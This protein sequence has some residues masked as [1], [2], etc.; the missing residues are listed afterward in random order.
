MNIDS[1]VLDVLSNAVINDNALTLTGTLDRKLYEA[2]NKVL[3]AAGGKWNRKAK[4]HLFD[5]EAAEIMDAIILTGKVTDKKS[6]LGYF[7]TPKAIVARLLELAHIE[8]GMSVAEP[9]AGQGAIAVEVYK[10]SGNVT[11]FELDKSNAIV[12]SQKLAETVLHDFKRGYP[13]GFEVHHGDFLA[14]EPNPIFDRIVMNPPFAKRQD[15][16]HVRHAYKFLK[17]SGTLVSV[18]SAGVEFRTDRIGNEF[19]QFVEDHGGLIERLPE[20]SFLE[21]GTG[22]NTVIV[23][24]E[25]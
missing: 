21:S 6:E 3:E 8:Q 4:A 20:G 16:Q 7:P 2:T 22:V 14:I 24:L 17:P 23:T 10:L 15:I 18:M 12:L 9:E 1:T 25:A 11:C 19:R 5:G 13:M